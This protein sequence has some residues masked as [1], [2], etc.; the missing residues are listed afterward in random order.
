VTGVHLEYYDPLFETITFQRGLPSNLEFLTQAA[1]VD[2]RDIIRTA[3]FARLAFLRR[4]GLAWLIFP[5]AVHTRFAH[6]IGYWGLARL[7]ESLIKVEVGK[8]QSPCALSLWLKSIELREEFYLGLL[9]HDIGHGPLSDMLERNEEFIAGL[10]MENNDC[11]NYEQRGAAL[12]EGNGELA[13]TWRQIARSRYGSDV[14]TLKDI[15]ENLDGSD[16]TLCIHAIC[17]FITRNIKHLDKCTHAHKEYLGVVKDLL[18]GLLVLRQLDHYAQD[19]YFSGLR[20]YSINLRGF[21]SNLNIPVSP[22]DVDSTR[23][24]VVEA[25]IPY[26]AGLLAGKRQSLLTSFRNPQIIALHSMVDWALSAYL[27][28]LSDETS[29]A[30]ACT[31]LAFMEDAQFVEIITGIEHTGCRYIGQRIRAVRPYAYVGK[32]QTYQPQIVLAEMAGTFGEPTKSINGDHPELLFH[33]GNNLRGPIKEALDCFNPNRIFIG[34]THIP[35]A[36]HP[37]YKNNFQHLEDAARHSYLYLFLRDEQR[38][39]EIKLKAQSICRR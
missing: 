23:F 7:A 15:L 38:T 4:T 34:D 39:E 36:Q 14:T 1:S 28:N 32:W 35:L 11:L 12:L 18:S 10:R 24:S 26:A 37:D 5:S 29:R 31:Q 22:S 27:H 6:A 2:P 21:L 20:R 30:N 17:Y 8:S 19:S 16:R 3:E 33:I 25:G 13:K 9:C